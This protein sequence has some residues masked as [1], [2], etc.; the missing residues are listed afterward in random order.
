MQGASVWTIFTVSFLMALS[1]A[2]MPGPLFTYTIART[3][4]TEKKGFMTGVWVVA[5]HAALEMVL[6]AGLVLGIAEFLKAPLAI[7]IIGALGALLLGYMGISLVVEAVRGKSADP[8][9]PKGA[10]APDDSSAGAS[11][12]PEA[13]AAAADPG[14]AV[15]RMHPVLAGILISM[16]NPY[17]WVWWV[18][19]GS[20]TLMGFGVSLASWQGLVAFFLGHEAADLGWYFMVSTLTHLGR[21]RI[22]GGFYRAVLVICGIFISGFGIY[23]GLSALLKGA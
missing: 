2:L 23:L 12:T 20:A 21:R 15:S 19:A 17:W 4:K 16:S 3:M 18:T 1:G 10:A 14:S 13:A 9:A 6:L 5:G 11:A 22:S 8:G 7:K